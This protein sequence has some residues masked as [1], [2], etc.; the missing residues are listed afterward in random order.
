MGATLF[1]V[2]RDHNDSVE[3]NA[4]AVEDLL[5]RVEALEALVGTQASTI[6][7]LEGQLDA[8]LVEADLASLPA[9]AFPARW[10]RR[11]S[12]TMRAAST[13]CRRQARR[14][15]PDGEDLTCIKPVLRT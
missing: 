3:A 7:T 5:G 6:S 14:S 13:T 11:L 9:S 4:S 12:W 10:P 2:P 1:P 15:S 8:C